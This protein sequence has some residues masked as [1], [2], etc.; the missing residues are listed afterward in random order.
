M[1]SVIRQVFNGKILPNYILL[2]SKMQTF[3]VS[4]THIIR[5]VTLRYD[6]I[7]YRNCIS[8]K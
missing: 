8:K 1:S 2:K 7:K 4:I 6:S 5:D 3:K